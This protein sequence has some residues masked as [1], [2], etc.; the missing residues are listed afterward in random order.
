MREELNCPNC[1]APIKKDRCEYCGT[2]FFDLSDME[3]NRESFLK[4]KINDNILFAKVIPR[5]ITIENSIDTYPYLT[6]G[7][8]ARD[9]Y[10][11]QKGGE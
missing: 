11:K 6:I 8:M 1:G 3:L 2:Q 4:I 5:E 7:F 9:I 10:S